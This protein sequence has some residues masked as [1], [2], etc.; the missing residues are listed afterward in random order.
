MGQLIYFNSSI[1][2]EQWIDKESSGV[3][4]GSLPLLNQEK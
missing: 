2:R 3:G 4:A 1:S